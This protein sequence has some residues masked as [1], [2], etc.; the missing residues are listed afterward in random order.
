MVM[1]CRKNWLEKVCRH[2]VEETLP[3]VRGQR[4]ERISTVC[5]YCICWLVL[6]RERFVRGVRTLRHLKQK[7]TQKARR[8]QWENNRHNRISV[9]MRI[10]QVVGKVAQM[11]LFGAVVWYLEVLCETPR[12]WC[13]V[14]SYRA[15]KSQCQ[16]NSDKKDT[17]MNK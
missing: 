8:G 14:H 16:E 7:K 11:V 4:T 15:W 12:D 9:R 6:S 17:K 10:K 3:P 1:K 2:H 13:C 5:D